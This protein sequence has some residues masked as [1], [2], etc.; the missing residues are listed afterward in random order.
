MKILLEGKNLC[1]NFIRK[2]KIIGR[3]CD[4]PHGTAICIFLEVATNV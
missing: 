4:I 3:Q 2:Q 1:D